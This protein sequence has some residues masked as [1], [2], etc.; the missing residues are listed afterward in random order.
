MTNLARGSVLFAL[1]ALIGFLFYFQTTVVAEG[2]FSIANDSKGNIQLQEILQNKQINQ[3][4][5]QQ[6][7]SVETT[8]INLKYTNYTPF[9]GKSFRATAYCLK[10]R[11]A[12]GGSVRRGIVAADRRVLPLGTRIQ[13]SAGSYSGTYTVADTGGSVKGNTLDIWVPSCAEANRFG[14]KTISVSVLGRD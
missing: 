3:E 6:N 11:T 13:I 12:S 7:N 4:T 5:I 8:L 1:T 2:T 14:R 9:E 10:G